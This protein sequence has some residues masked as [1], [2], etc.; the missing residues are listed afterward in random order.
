M[1]E[2]DG[3]PQKEGIT[4]KNPGGRIQDRKDKVYSLCDVTNNCSSAR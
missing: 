2:E 1:T 3:I 4:K